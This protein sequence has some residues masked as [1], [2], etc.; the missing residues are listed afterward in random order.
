M[1]ALPAPKATS[2]TLFLCRAVGVPPPPGAAYGLPPGGG[3][4]GG[5]RG[6]GRGY[7]GGYNRGGYGG[8]GGRGGYNNN[9]FFDNRADEDPFAADE[10]K[11][12]EAD[13]I[14]GSES[15]AI[16]FDVYDDIPVE[17]SGHNVPL[18]IA[19]FADAGMAEAVLLNIQ[20]C[21]YT[22]P[23]PVQKHAIP[24]GMGGRDLMACA[25]TGSGKTAAFCFPIICHMLKNGF[26]PSGRTRKAMPTA[27][28]LAPT[29][30]LTSQIYEEARKFAYQTG[31]RPVVI[32]GGAPVVNQVSRRHPL[33]T[34]LLRLPTAPQP[35]SLAG[36]C[37]FFTLL[38]RLLQRGV[39]P[40]PPAVSSA[41]P[42]S[43][44]SLGGSAFGALV[45]PPHHARCCPQSYAHT[46]AFF[47]LLPPPLTF[48]G[49]PPSP[50]CFS[51]RLYHPFFT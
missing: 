22:K 19:N 26:E 30:E 44:S 51:L 2:L 12:R 46:L 47:A 23:T 40:P 41:V 11:K 14:L 5:G 32:Y 27:L 7:G 43:G 21:K 6:G 16:N 28:V 36:R 15:T 34:L 39:C 50:L 18:P 1:A 33:R 29:R 9:R 38:S 31:I 13:G 20:R 10:A 4:G 25:Q 42:A 45:L 37:H 3:Y 35:H 8:R 49:L 48:G 24:I 17:T